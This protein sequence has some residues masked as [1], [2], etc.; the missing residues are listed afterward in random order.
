MS[1]TFEYYHRIGAALFPLPRGQKSPFGIIES[2]V[3]DCSHNPEQWAKWARENPGCNWGMVAGPSRLIVIDID[4][5]KVGREA[6]WETW[7]QWCLSNNLPVFS[8]HV[9]TPSLGFHI[10]FACDIADLRQPPLV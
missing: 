4:T 8:P 1:D 10:Y 6:A 7:R 5:K 2:F 3:K 9:S